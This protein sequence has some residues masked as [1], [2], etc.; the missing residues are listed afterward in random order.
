MKTLL[1][2][3]DLAARRGTDKEIG[4]VQQII[5]Y[6]PEITTIMG[7]T[8]PGTFATAKVQI[9]IPKGGGFRA[10][11]ARRF[12]MFGAIHRVFIFY[13]EATRR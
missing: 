6:S 3:A 8:V 9:G 1:T 2:M 4:L 10:V 7:R 11:N 12:G 13:L 5:N